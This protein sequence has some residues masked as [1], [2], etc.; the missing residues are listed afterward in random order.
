MAEQFPATGAIRGGR[1]VLARTVLTVPKGAFASVSSRVERKMQ[2]AMFQVG[3]KIRDKARALAPK[4]TGALA[5]SIYVSKGA[6]DRS[7]GAAK[8]VGGN[9]Y[10]KQSTLTYFRAINAAVGKYNKSRIGKARSDYKGLQLLDS[11]VVNTPTQRPLK[12]ASYLFNMT[13]NK[14]G[15]HMYDT[16]NSGRVGNNEDFEGMS[17]AQAAEA[18]DTDAEV[19]MPSIMH[20]G[21][22]G[23][24][25]FF[26]TVGA[27]AF[28]A[29]Y[30]E[31]GHMAHYAWVPPHPFLGPAVEWGKP[32]AEREV[33]RVVNE[34]AREAAAAARV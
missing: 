3:R 5:A 17:E 25:S 22:T 6:V 32:I 8:H 19:L 15:G 7:I 13:K 9:A 16:F 4:K 14:I 2:E 24:Q 28:Y 27:A 10:T 33:G 1:V 21:G 23:R 30:V 20:L 29:G 12:S 11:D 31:F 18:I 34:A 26:V